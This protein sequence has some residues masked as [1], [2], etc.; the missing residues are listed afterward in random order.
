MSS[1]PRLASASLVGTSFACAARLIVS[2]F[3]LMPNW[4]EGSGSKASESSHR[5][6]SLPDS[7]GRVLVEAAIRVLL[8]T[9]RFSAAVEVETV[10]RL[11]PRAIAVR[12]KEAWSFW[13]ETGTNYLVRRRFTP[14]SGLETIISTNHAGGRLAIGSMSVVVPDNVSLPGFELL[15]LLREMSGAQPVVTSRTAGRQEVLAAAGIT[16]LRAW[17]DS[18][19][20][21]PSRIEKRIESKLRLVLTR[22]EAVP[23]SVL[24]ARS[25]LH[26]YENGRVATTVLRSFTANTSSLPM[27]SSSNSVKSFLP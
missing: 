4:L 10:D 20:V 24:P 7:T 6:A 15:P 21:L 16:E 2:V 9:A 14:Q 17:F 12:A 8:N 13:N 26:F 1:F 25:A 19:Q 3:L 11:D 18:D 22:V 27:S 5:A 23:A